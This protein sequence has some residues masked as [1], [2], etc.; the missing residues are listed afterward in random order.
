[1]DRCSPTTSCKIWANKRDWW[2]RSKELV[3]LAIP[4]HRPSLLTWPGSK[5]A[6][7][8]AVRLS[9]QSWLDKLSKWAPWAPNTRKG[10]PQSM[11]REAQRTTFTWSSNFSKTIAPSTALKTEHL[12]WRRLQSAKSRTVVN[13][14]TSSSS[15]TEKT[16]LLS[17][18]VLRSSELMANFKGSRSKTVQM[19]AK[20]VRRWSF[21]E[22]KSSSTCITIW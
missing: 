20:T 11:Q 8:M 1:M 15:S 7:S 19:L 22:C 2:W 3:P 17:S 6:P 5:V 21:L 12:W 10:P 13:L 16:T 14:Y 4:L 9:N 18:I